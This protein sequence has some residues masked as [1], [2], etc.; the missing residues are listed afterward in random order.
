MVAPLLAVAFATLGEL[1]AAEPSA[2]SKGRVMLV[3]SS[4][5][6]DAFG[7]IVVDQLERAGYDVARR[8]YPSAGLSRP[9]FHDISAEVSKL[10]IGPSATSVMLYLGG[11]DAQAL[12]LTP[13]ER[14][15]GHDAWI[16]W[17]DERWPGIYERRVRRLIDETC[18]RG[19]KRVVVLAPVD[20]A[21]AAMQKKLDRVRAAQ[22]RAAESSA[23]GQFVSTSG[24]ADA[25]GASKPALRDA[26]GVHMTR[27]GATR[28]WGRIE[29]RVT[30]LIASAAPR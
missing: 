30:T 7:D 11:N 14:K 15:A 2:P 18:A 10:P 27:A 16:K 22:R 19:A 12:W 26:R 8:G 9:D 1:A 20:V 3:G 6:N 17:D 25:L 29:K 5:V 4:S 28:V 21:R 23:C 13:S 24:D